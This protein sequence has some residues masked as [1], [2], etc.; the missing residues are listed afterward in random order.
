MKRFL[1]VARRPST[2]AIVW[3]VVVPAILAAPALV[4]QASLGPDALLD[5]DT[6]TRTGSAPA[7]PKFDDSSPVLFDYP[8]DL[9]FARGLHEGR[10]DTW[11]TLVGTGAPMWA[12]EHGPFVPFK[13]PFYASPT[14]TGYNWFL[15]LR[16]V[17]AGIGAYA[18][19]RRRG[20]GI[21]AAVVAGTLFELSGEIV[22]TASFGDTSAICMLP[23]LLLGARA[24]ADNRSLG[25]AVGTACAVGVA[26]NGGH[27]EISFLILLG[28]AAAMAAHVLRRI[29]QPRAALQIAG[30]GALA[31]AFG[32]ALAAPTLLPLHELHGQS[33]SYKHD[34]FGE[35]VYTVESAPQP[36][37]P[38][39]RA[40]RPPAPP[41]REAGGVLNWPWGMNPAL[42]FFGVVLAV[43]G[44][45]ELDVG[46]WAVLLLGLGLTIAPP[47]LRWL[48]S[49]PLLHYI[50]PSYAWSLVTL[51]LAQ[52]AGSA[53]E[54]LDRPRGRRMLGGRARGRRRRARLVRRDAASASRAHVRARPRHGAREASFGAGV[55]PITTALAVAALFVL[56]RTALRGARAVRRARR[57]HDRGLSHDD[58]A[59]ALSRLAAPRGAADAGDP[60]AA[61][62][63]RE[64][65][66]TARR[67]PAQRRAARLARALRPAGSARDHRA[68]IARYVHYLAMIHPLSIFTTFTSG[69]PR[70][71]LVDLAAVTYVVAQKDDQSI[72]GLRADA[73]FKQVFETPNETIDENTAARPRVRIE[74]DVTVARDEKDAIAKLAPLARQQHVDHAP[75]VLEGSPPPLEDACAP[76]DDE[77]VTI[78]DRRDP[79][80]LV[81]D[82][83]L[84]KPAYVVVADAYYPGWR[85]TV[86]GASTPIY[87]ADVLFRAIRV[88]AGAHRI[89]FT[90]VCEPLREGAAIALAA[91]LALAA[92][93]FRRRLARLSRRSAPSRDPS[94]SG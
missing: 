24:I 49:L 39:A 89:V 1:E 32:L 27:P 70:S 90:Y 92:I 31:F 87:A 64:R 63:P 79:A 4:G 81:L 66:R 12:D 60:R 8:R 34:A 26:A 80:R 23:W 29:A 18:L 69:T 59:R 36:R 35:H 82:A 88:P 41:G 38:A 76:A 83:Q 74:R 17:C 16:F 86:D 7:R 85:A 58:A 94:A 2:L 46:M 48:H 10:F 62:R 72:V 71:A 68:A 22:A 44:L 55:A 91:A 42:G 9:S 54:R 67:V 57:R 50:L 21:V 45:V 84:D 11:T 33:L 51:P 13:L 65:R 15:F 25:A 28:F 43:A 77:H 93:F 3:L 40:P 61:N 52:A 73:A 75:L 6:L 53:V 14:R 19:G 78:A 5:Q 30:L 37:E 20:L 56:A 47:G